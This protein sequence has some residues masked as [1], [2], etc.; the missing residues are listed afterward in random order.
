[1]ARALKLQKILVPVG[2]VSNLQQDYGVSKVMV[3]RA[4]KYAS[5]SDKAKAIRRDAVEKYGGV[6]AKVPTLV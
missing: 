3:Y 1:M 4:L 5:N 2:C 6:E